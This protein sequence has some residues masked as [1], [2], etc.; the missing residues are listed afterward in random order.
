MPDTHLS[1]QATAWNNGS[2]SRTGGGYGLKISIEDRDRHFERDWK[3]VMI[4]LIGKRTSGI[5]EA[6]VAKGSFW[7]QECRELIKA[8]IGRWFIENGLAPWPP[9]PPPRFRMLRVADR[10]FEVRPNR[11]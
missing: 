11:S 6:N 2:W 1:F 8:E 9:L 3:S 4:R 7:N 5:A 10:E